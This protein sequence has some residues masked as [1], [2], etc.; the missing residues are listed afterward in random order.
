MSKLK[1]PAGLPSLPPTWL[2]KLMLTLNFMPPAPEPPFKKP[3]NWA[4]LTPEER[5]NLRIEAWKSGVAIKFVDSASEARY[6]ERVQLLCDAISIDHKPARVPTFATMGIYALKRLG[7]Q[8]KDIFYDNHKEAAIAYTRFATDFEPDSNFLGLLFSGPALEVLDYQVLRWPGKGLPPDKSYQYLEQEFMKADEYNLFLDDPSD[9]MLRKVVPRMYKSLSGLSDFPKFAQAAIGGS[10]LFLNFLSPELKTALRTMKKA[11]E[12]T[13]L[14]M[15]AYGAAMND[16]PAMGF[17]MLH[18]SISMAPFDMV[19]DILRSTRGVM[20]DMYRRKDK[21]IEACDRYTS[22]AIEKP[23]LTFSGSPLVFIPLHKGS[24]RFMS[25][26]QFETFY[27]PSLKKLMLGL[28]E[29]GFIPAPFAEGSY[30]HRLETIADFPEGGAV[31]MFD[32]TDMGRA[33]EVIGD[34]LA[35]AGNVPA[36]LIATG[37]PEQMTA[38][39]KELIETCGPKGNFILCPGC[40][41]DHASDENIRAMLNSVKQFGV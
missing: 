27:W 24:D 3:D 8:P 36:S 22:F 4:S 38:Y 37:T 39:C 23:L 30:N 21:L 6:K 11:A 20:T 33:A 2:V 29:D 28:V 35:F 19:G 14:I 5:R 1:N 16:A 17:P 10:E 18:G 9:F 31:W 34:R 7:L 15:P 13:A 12:L 26:D 25:K 40:Q 41:I 32:Q